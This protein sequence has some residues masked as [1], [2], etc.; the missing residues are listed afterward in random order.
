VGFYKDILEALKAS[1]E[2]KALLNMS[3][4]PMPMKIERKELERFAASDRGK[5]DCKKEDICAG[6]FYNPGLLSTI[7]VVFLIKHGIL[8]LERRLLMKSLDRFWHVF[9]W[10]LLLSHWW[11]V[12]S[13]KRIMKKLSLNS[14]RLKR[15][16]I[17][18]PQS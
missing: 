5:G 9:S 15:T 12:G 17:K 11:A 4:T 2:V 14:A 6:I 10:W 8:S 3:E 13:A 1:E 7:R 16:W 18:A